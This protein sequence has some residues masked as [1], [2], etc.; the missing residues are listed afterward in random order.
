MRTTVK[1][2]LCTACGANFIGD[3]DEPPSGRA[4]RQTCPSCSGRLEYGDAFKD[5]SGV[6]HKD[7]GE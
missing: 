1:R 3:A 4:G 5:E 7:K 2:W 6:I